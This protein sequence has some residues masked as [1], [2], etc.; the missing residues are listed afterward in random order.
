V[1]LFFLYDHAH[2]AG[3][4]PD[5]PLPPG[6][7]SFACSDSF[8]APDLSIRPMLSRLQ[9]VSAMAAHSARHH[10]HSR[11]HYS[12]ILQVAGSTLDHHH[13]R[14]ALAIPILPVLPIIRAACMQQHC[15][16][17]PFTHTTHSCPPS[18]LS[19]SLLPFPPLP[20]ACHFPF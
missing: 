6:G 4:C 5:L 10:P 7:E 16:A 12:L 2:S 3:F 14:G 15:P 13:T 11:S 1:P 18:S 19:C 8:C 9:V 17:S 20:L